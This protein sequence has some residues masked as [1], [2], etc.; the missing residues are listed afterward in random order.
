MP[1]QP[2]FVFWIAGYGCSGPK[3][4]LV[5]RAD[6]NDL[7]YLLQGILHNVSSGCDLFLLS[8]SVYTIKC[9]V[10]YHGIPL[11]LHE[12]NMICSC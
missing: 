1:A 2:D 11:R 10:L 9:L 5:H 12:K 4:D 8:D 6:S 3:S 7:A